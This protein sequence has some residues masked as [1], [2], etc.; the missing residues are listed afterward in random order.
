[1]LLDVM[2]RLSWDDSRLVLLTNNIC[3][4]Q[5]PVSGVELLF[6]TLTGLRMGAHWVTLREF[7]SRRPAAQPAKG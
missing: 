3:L 4:C 7:P 5:F 6:V 1:M 2:P